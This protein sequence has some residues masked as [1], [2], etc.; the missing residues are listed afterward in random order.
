M[1]SITVHKRLGLNARLTFCPKC[2]GE[3]SGLVML[4]RKN[5]KGMCSEHGHVYGIGPRTTHCIAEGCDR[6]LTEV[7]ELAD[8]E[9]VPSVELC[10]ACQK[11]LT[12]QMEAIDRGGIA[13]QCSTCGSEGAVL[14]GGTFDEMIKKVRA[15]GYTGVRWSQCPQCVDNEKSI[16]GEK[17]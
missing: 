4:G 10:D 5:Y 14:P 15:Q 1:G 11:S 6:V 13:W 3:G 17:T 8:Y 7:K 12:I 16:E 2:G 9:K